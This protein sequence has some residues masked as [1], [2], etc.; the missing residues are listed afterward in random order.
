MGTAKQLLPVD[1]KPMIERVLQAT[2]GLPI[3]EE[4]VVLGSDAAQIVHCIPA[5]YQVVVNTNWHSGISS[6]LQAG[7]ARVSAEAEAALFILADQP[8]LTSSTLETIL[9]AYF[10]TQLGIVVP[11][12]RGQRGNPVLFDRRFFHL[13]DS[14]RGDSG[15][16]ELIQKMRE[17]VLPVEVASAE[18]LVDI[19]TEDD[20]RQHIGSFPGD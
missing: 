14:M 15:G 20:Y 10:G 2:A 13:L 11:R 6:S 1:G 17:Q 9:Y 7:L 19:D 4:I 5:R 3:R 18:A 16:R 12:F 8:L